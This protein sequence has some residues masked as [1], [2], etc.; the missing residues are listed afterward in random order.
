MNHWTIFFR[1]IT[2]LCIL[3][4]VYLI[5]QPLNGLWIASLERNDIL[6]D[7]QIELHKQNLK[8]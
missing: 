3:I 5:L 8:Q 6:S 2:I 1:L 7:I 4:S